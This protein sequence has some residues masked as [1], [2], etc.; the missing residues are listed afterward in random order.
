MCANQSDGERIHTGAAERRCEHVAVRCRS[1]THSSLAQAGYR[2]SASGSNEEEERENERK[3]KV[4]HTPRRCRTVISG[5]TPEP[6]EM[7]VFRLIP[8]IAT[9][10][11]PTR[12][13]RLAAT[14]PR[15]RSGVKPLRGTVGR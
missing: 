2:D 6:L 5:F 12:F 10:P 1:R 11:C 4:Q 3:T 9:G 14:R 15:L 8:W 13:P 7:H